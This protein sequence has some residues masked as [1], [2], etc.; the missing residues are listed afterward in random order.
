MSE[1]KEP[2]ISFNDSGE[3]RPATKTVRLNSSKSRFA[4]TKKI[5]EEFEKQAQDIHS[6]KEGYQYEAIQL[7][8][9]FNK[10]INR[11]TL[12]KN[13][14]PLEKT[15]ETELINKLIDYAIR[16]NNDEHERYDGMGSVA[17]ITLLYNTI[18]KMKDNQNNL[19]YSL[20]LL[21]KK[22]IELESKIK[23]EEKN[24]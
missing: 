3:V 7:G 10:F 23:P 1:N 16:V 19:E 14:G 12:S 24:D 5:K 20:R 4:Q 11:K 17:L 13:K 22:V 15:F 8:Q 9:E 2:R 6:K 18:I 21:E